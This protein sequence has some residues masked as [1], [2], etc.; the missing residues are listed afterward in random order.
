MLRL[1]VAFL[2]LLA[3][4]G[5]PAQETVF[6]KCTD[7]KGNVSMQNGTPCAAGMKQD[8]KRVREVRTVPV[9]DRKPA[10]ESAPAAPVYGEFVLVS[11]PNMKRNPSPEAAGLPPPPPLFQCKTWEGNDYLGDID[12]PPARCMPLQVTG[13]DGSLALG[14]GEACEMKPDQCTAVPAESVCEGW[15]RRLDEADFKRKYAGNDNQA[16]RDD[17]FATIDTKV[18]ASNCSPVAPE[19]GPVTPESAD[20]NP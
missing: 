5:A 7:A 9:P 15:L 14:A 10:V 20:Q 13:I 17:A 6:Y 3:L 11:G 16:E 8:I 1:G 18:K 2:L 19:A 12:N 4:R